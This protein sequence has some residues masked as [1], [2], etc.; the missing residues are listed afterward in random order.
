[1]A[2]GLLTSAA[3]LVLQGAIAGGTPVWSALSPSVIGEVL[4]TRFGE[5]G[6]VRLVAW[7][8]AGALLALA[9]RPNRGAPSLMLRDE[10]PSFAALAALAVVA[11]SFGL[12]GHAGATEPR[13]LL[14]AADAVHV[15]A[16]AAWLGGLVLVLAAVPAATRALDPADRTRLL[17]ATL[18]RFSPLALA[19]VA[20]LVAT[21]VAQSIVHLTAFG[22]LLDTAFG[23]AILVKVVLLGGIVALGAL[24]QRRLLPRLRR[25]A[26]DGGPPGR[27][28]RALR[29]AIRA[30]VVLATAILGATAALV[31]YA[32]ASAGDGV[33]AE[34]LTVGPA[35][36]EL[37]VAP[38]RAG[39]QEVHLYLFDARTGAPLRALDE[40]TLTVAL[41]DKDVGP[42]EVDLRRAGPG[43]FTTTAAPVSPAG[44]WELSLRLRTN[45]LDVHRVT[46]PVKVR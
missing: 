40:V 22:D 45:R 36:A 2:A 23:R 19:S 31:S 27:P 34:S 3:A 43:H 41:P 32:P 7:A 38:L 33:L 44:D 17:A 15:V 46:V 26:A 39:P 11:V 18:G 28:G 24:N 35:R 13:W 21:G 6:L 29:D 37:T 42:L 25:L 12:G 30:E 5:V 4:E 20:L 14:L 1:V 16:M 9:L 10:A 8:V